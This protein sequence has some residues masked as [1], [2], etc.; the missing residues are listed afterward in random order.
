MDLEIHIK[1]SHEQHKVFQCDQFENNITLK[2]RLQKHMKLHTEKNV[3]Y[4]LRNVLLINMNVNF[5]IMCQK[6]ACIIRNVK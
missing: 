3:N 4:F 1:S 5:C 2:W 6:N